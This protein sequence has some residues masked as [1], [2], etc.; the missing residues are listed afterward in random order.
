[1]S[2]Y[3]QLL[4]KIRR[5]RRALCNYT[6]PRDEVALGGIRGWTVPRSELLPLMVR[7]SR[8]LRPRTQPPFSWYKRSE[9]GFRV[10]LFFSA[11]SV[12][13]AFGGLLAVRKIGVFSRTPIDLT[14]E[15][16]RSR[17]WP[18][19]VGNLA[20]RGSLSWKVL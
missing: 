3:R 2:D 17:R 16:P 5:V 11:A 1:V 15:R 13:G 7:S 6:P 18:G 10:A 20:G 12:S 9:L 8:P 19:S 4:C 14:S